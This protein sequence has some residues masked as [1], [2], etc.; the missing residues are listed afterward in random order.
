MKNGTIPER[1]EVEWEVKGQTYVLALPLRQLR[2]IDAKLSTKSLMAL[3]APGTRGIFD[4]KTEDVVVILQFGLI[5]GGNSISDEDF[6]VLWD[7]CGTMEM[8]TL[9]DRLLAANLKGANKEP[10]K[11]D[12]PLPEQPAEPSS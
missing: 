10:L 2:T 8:T 4:A 9:C 3:M 1:G 5:G 12:P 7:W 11:S 6:E